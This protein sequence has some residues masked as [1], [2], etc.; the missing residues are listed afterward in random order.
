MTRGMWLYAVVALLVTLYQGY[1]GFMFQ[2]LPEGEGWI[3]TL[4][5]TRKVVLL[6]ISDTLLYLVSTA[7]GFLAL[8]L[9]YGLLNRAIEKLPE[10]GTGMSVILVFLALFGILG[11]T[12]QLPHL[13]QQGKL[14]PKG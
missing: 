14:L 3:K 11:V 8:L 12:G 9:A 10:L 7:S 13:L 1:R 2:W 6:C 5:P 4:T